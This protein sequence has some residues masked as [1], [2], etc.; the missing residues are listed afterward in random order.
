MAIDISA[1][2]QRLNNLAN[3]FAKNGNANH[4][5]QLRD[6]AVAVAGGPSASWWA[7]VDV[8]RILDPEKLTDNLHNP[9]WV[10]V[11][12]AVRNV[13][14]LLPLAVTWF[15]I[16]AA[17]T[18]YHGLIG[19]KPELAAQ[20][21]IY[22]WQTGFEGRTPFTLS[23]VA[24]V[25]VVLLLL[26]AVLTGC[27]YIDYARHPKHDDIS[28]LHQ[29]LA[30][31]DLA[32]AVYRQPQGFGPL[33]QM[34]QIAE[35]MA[36]SLAQEGAQ[37][38]AGLRQEGE[39]MS[40]S[41]QQAAQQLAQTLQQK[42][43]QLVYA[44][45]QEHQRVRQ[46][47]EQREKE[48]GSLTAFT[49]GLDKASHELLLSASSLQQA[50]VSTLQAINALAM[51]MQALADQT[52]DLG[53]LTQEVSRKLETLSALQEQNVV[54]MSDAVKQQK[55]LVGQV[56]A[57]INALTGAANA[58]VQAANALSGVA[59]QLANGQTSLIASLANERQAQANLADVVSKVNYNLDLSLQQI[60]DSAVRLHGIAVDL[61]AIAQTLP[62]VLDLLRGN[63]G[64]MIQ[65]HTDAAS[66]IADASQRI[67]SAAGAVEQLIQG[68]LPALNAL[69]QYASAAGQRRTWPGAGTSFTPSQQP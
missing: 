6:L 62:P 8:F 14:V 67:T 40:Q 68:L 39:Q 55:A 54:G 37:L 57:A 36:Q 27:V 33:I 26:V 58:T 60:H 51:P 66:R 18:S 9:Y 22:L 41:L 63:L 42:A 12:E 13:L 61:T 28:E 16:G 2:Q 7:F 46:L 24:I 20:S 43:D 1:T 25:D 15:G 10:R 31:A 47:S 50:H 17:V 11:L 56:S 69:T 34:Q 3:R 65:D 19:E 59:Q 48:L 35:Q 53:P 32:L 4:A 23:V 30:E 21:F 45:N 49:A 38:A 52:R 29:A 5:A 44:L 64:Q